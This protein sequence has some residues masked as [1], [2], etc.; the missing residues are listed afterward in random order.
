MSFNPTAPTW[1]DPRR[2]TRRERPSFEAWT[3]VAPTDRPRRLAISAAGRLAARLFSNSLSDV[4]QRLT[5]YGMHGAS[6]HVFSVIKIWRKSKV[7]VRGFKIPSLKFYSYLMSAT[8]QTHAEC[9]S[10]GAMGLFNIL[11]WRARHECFQFSIRY[12]PNDCRAFVGCG[13]CKRC[14]LHCHRLR[15]RWTFIRNGEYHPKTMA[16]SQ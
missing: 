12:R 15:C 13:S 14:A 1:P 10:E 3:K 8:G 4:V 11:F 6:F 2:G 16:A 7:P 9:E 5:R